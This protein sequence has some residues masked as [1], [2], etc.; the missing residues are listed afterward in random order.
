M[1]DFDEDDNDGESFSKSAEAALG[2]IPKHK[3]LDP[4]A[5]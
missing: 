3:I 5:R 4:I 1:P 2:T